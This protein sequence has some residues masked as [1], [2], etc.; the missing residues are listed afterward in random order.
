MASSNNVQ[1]THMSD[2]LRRLHFSLIEIV[3]AMNRAQN[4]ETLLRDA[5]VKLDRALL[6]LLVGIERLGPISVGEIADR[7]G[8]DYTTIS[9]Q[10]KKLDE[11]GLVERTPGETDQRVSLARVTA[12][13]HRMTGALDDARERLARLALADWDVADLDQLVGLLERL[14]A[15]MRGGPSEP[16]PE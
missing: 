14:T 12:Q 2:L 15:A 8:R 7:T 5:G 1:D 6:P 4:D 13:G 9:R 16:R 11:L 3:S 10:L